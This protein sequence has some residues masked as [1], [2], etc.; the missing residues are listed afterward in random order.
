M[1]SPADTLTQPIFPLIFIDSDPSASATFDKPSGKVTLT[2]AGPPSSAFSIYRNSDGQPEPRARVWTGPVAI[3]ITP[4]E[5]KAP[6]KKKSRLQSA[7]GT[8]LMMS[9]ME[10]A[11][12]SR[13]H[14][15]RM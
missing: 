8:P 2:L 6:N 1:V 11:V 14:Q 5:A 7:G 4:E 12:V 15:G 10:G 3:V 9:L 13:P